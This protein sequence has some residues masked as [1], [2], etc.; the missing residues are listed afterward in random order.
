VRDLLSK[1]AGYLF[2]GGLAAIVDVG[3]FALLIQ[4]EMPLLP[5]AAVS[6]ILAAIVNFQVSSRFVF[7]RQATGRRFAVFLLAALLGLAINVYI[8]VS[9]A[10]SFY[11]PPIYAKIAGIAV[12][13]IVN[14]LLNL[15]LVFRVNDKNQM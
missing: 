3:G 13:L 15:L 4:A 12:A 7:K 14:F 9:V 1:F 2:S 8:T 10:R 5:A 11:L 6:F